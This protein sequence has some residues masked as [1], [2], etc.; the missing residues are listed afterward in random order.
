MVYWGASRLS[1]CLCMEGF[2]VSGCCCAFCSKAE[3]LFQTLPKGIHCPLATEDAGHLL[4]NFVLLS[5]IRFRPFCS[6]CQPDLYDSSEILHHTPN[7]INTETKA[8]LRIGPSRGSGE[9][10]SLGWWWKGS[11]SGLGRAQERVKK[12]CVKANSLLVSFCVISS[13]VG[14]CSTHCIYSKAQCHTPLWKR[15]LRTIL[16]PPQPSRAMPLP[17]STPRPPSIQHQ[18]LLALSDPSLGFQA[19]RCLLSWRPEGERNNQGC[20]VLV[21]VCVLKFHCHRSGSKCRQESK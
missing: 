17:P 3:G 6:L 8:E 7:L 13:S 21:E 19:P 5:R 2:E 20:W 15:A 9:S 1:G 14:H 18:C 4:P 12:A 10:A 16:F 11:G